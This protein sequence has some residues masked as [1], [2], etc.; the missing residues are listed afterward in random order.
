MMLG[1]FFTEMQ[2]D[3]IDSLRIPPTPASPEKSTII[4]CLDRISVKKHLL[5]YHIFGRD[6]GSNSQVSLPLDQG[7]AHGLK[8]FQ[9]EYVLVL[10]DN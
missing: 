1:D 5:L 9:T 10:G 7:N 4:A 8:Q 2:N 6:H 3:S